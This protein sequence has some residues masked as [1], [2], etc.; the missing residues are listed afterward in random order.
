M[1]H[2][3]FL[4]TLY[5]VNSIVF[6]GGSLFA[7]AISKDDSVRISI[8]GIFL[9]ELLIFDIFYII[10]YVFNNKIDNDKDRKEVEDEKE[11]EEKVKQ[12]SFKD[13]DNRTVIEDENGNIESDDN[14]SIYEEEGGNTE[15][16][17]EQNAFSKK[18]KE[19]EILFNNKTEIDE[20]A[21]DKDIKQIGFDKKTEEIKKK[22][23]SEV[24]RA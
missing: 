1:K 13:F 6:L 14:E 2:F 15:S 7:L 23:N 22:A 19:E 18:A 3:D 17:P 12:D 21:R 11:K 9:I 8:I 5:A 24:N 16:G 4:F 20:K 10:N